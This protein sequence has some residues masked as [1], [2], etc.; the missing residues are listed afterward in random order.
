MVCFCQSIQYSYRR[1]FFAVGGVFFP[2]DRVQTPGFCGGKRRAFQWVVEV[3]V[4]GN[5][6]GELLIQLFDDSQCVLLL[7]ARRKTVITRPRASSA[8]RALMRAPRLRIKAL[9]LCACFI[10]S[11]AT[12]S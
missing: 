6:G 3:I 2:A 1:F 10:E 7:G 4:I 9:M 8:W 5:R 12:I 11:V